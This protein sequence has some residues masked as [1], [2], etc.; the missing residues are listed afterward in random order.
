MQARERGRKNAVGTDC[1][2]VP[3]L[4]LSPGRGEKKKIRKE[5]KEKR[6][7]EKRRGRESYEEMMPRWLAPRLLSSPLIFIST[8]E[9]GGGKKKKREGGKRASAREGTLHR[10]P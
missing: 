10:H 3:R 2:F 7:W 5:K 1:Y 6:R 4:I 8:F 9:R